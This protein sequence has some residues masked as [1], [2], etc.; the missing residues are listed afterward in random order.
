MIFVRRSDDAL[1]ICVELSLMRQCDLLALLSAQGVDRPGPQAWCEQSACVSSG[2]NVASLDVTAVDGPAA[3][4][5]KGSSRQQPLPGRRMPWPTT[6]I[7]V[8]Q[9]RK[10]HPPYY[11]KETTGGEQETHTTLPLP[12]QNQQWVLSTMPSIFVRA[13]IYILER[14]R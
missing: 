13:E 10:E 9:M 12:P 1:M 3:R 14:P 7:Q 5:A 4:S 11:C 8:D 6:T 2:R